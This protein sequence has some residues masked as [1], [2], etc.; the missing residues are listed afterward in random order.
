MTGK[1]DRIWMVLITIVNGNGNTGNG[2]IINDN[3][4]TDN[5]VINGKRH[6]VMMA[7]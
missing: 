3:N 7:L 1:Q 2:G 5:G 6:H 4:G